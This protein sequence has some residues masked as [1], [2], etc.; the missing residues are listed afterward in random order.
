MK[1]IEPYEDMQYD[2]NMACNRSAISLCYG[3]DVIINLNNDLLERYWLLRV[4]RD[5]IS[6][7]IW[8]T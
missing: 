5:S 6:E 8:F 7:A 2:I 3:E 4:Y 1:L